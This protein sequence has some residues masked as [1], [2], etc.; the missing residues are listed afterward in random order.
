M[1]RWIPC[2]TEMP[3]IEQTALVTW[4][5]GADR[6]VMPAVLIRDE[7]GTHWEADSEHLTYYNPLRV[8]AWQPLPKAYGG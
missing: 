3:P 2:T 4:L 7:R 5:Y 6:Y 8:I 1:S